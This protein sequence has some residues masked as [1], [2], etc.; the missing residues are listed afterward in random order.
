[1]DAVVTPVAL[2][3]AHQ[4]TGELFLALAVA[5]ATSQGEEFPAVEFVLR[6]QRRE[7][8]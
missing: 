5:V 2:S 3:H 1:M 7:Q 8:R 6:G 4:V